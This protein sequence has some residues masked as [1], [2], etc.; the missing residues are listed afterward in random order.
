MQERPIH[1]LSIDRF[2]SAGVSVSIGNPSI[3][4]LEAMGNGRSPFV[5]G[6][7][8]PRAFSFGSFRMIPHA[9]PVERDG[10]QMSLG[11]RAFDLL[12]V[13]VSRPGEVVSKGKLMAKVRPDLRGEESSLRFHVA[14]LQRALGDGQGDERYVTNVPGRGYCFVAPVDCA[15][16][17]CIQ[18]LYG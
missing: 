6:E 1:Q 13:L 5:R 10:S 14:Q 11:S 16:S 12:C 17:S 18:H 4:V 8:R 9:R 2:S 15:A 7:V 3:N